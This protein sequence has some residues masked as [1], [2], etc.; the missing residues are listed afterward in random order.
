MKKLFVTAF[1]ELYVSRVLK[2]TIVIPLEAH[3]ALGTCFHMG[4]LRFTPLL[5]NYS[6]RVSTWDLQFSSAFQMGAST[7]KWCS[8]FRLG[9]VELCFKEFLDCPTMMRLRSMSI[10]LNVGCMK[11]LPVFYF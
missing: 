8:W 1:K 5:I 2:K 9:E 6:L 7:K 3:Q 10:K 11:L 4:F